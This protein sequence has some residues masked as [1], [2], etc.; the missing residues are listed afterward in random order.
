V[1]DLQKLYREAILRHAAEPVG[2]DKPIESTHRHEADNP[3]CGDR[4]VLSLAVH[5][6]VI[7]DAAFTGEAC[8]ICT[9][10]ASLLCAHAIGMAATEISEQLDCL[11]TALRD[12]EGSASLG[13][14]SPLLGVRPYPGR[15]RCATLPWEAAAKAIRQG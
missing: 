12:S 1:T 5:D 14:L 8:A 13:E 15:I 6:G 11:D 3:L 10:S 2:F 9:A 4:I 7:E